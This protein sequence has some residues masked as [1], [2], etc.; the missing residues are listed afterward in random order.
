MQEGLI[1]LC[2]NAR[3]H[4]I[5]LRAL[6]R[7]K[8]TVAYPSSGDADVSACDHSRGIHREQRGRISNYDPGANVPRPSCV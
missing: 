2:R 4:I 1:R 3:T 5:G 7:C 6:L 8:K